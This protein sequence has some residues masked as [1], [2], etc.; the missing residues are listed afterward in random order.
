MSSEKDEVERFKCECIWFMI[1][2]FKFQ[3]LKLGRNP[4]TIIQV[5][6]LLMSKSN[7]LDFV[8]CL[9]GLDKTDTS[10]YKCIQ[11]DVVIW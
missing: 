9:K 2:A 3:V 10:T 7:P 8:R 5:Y 11:T 1:L 4:T 6:N